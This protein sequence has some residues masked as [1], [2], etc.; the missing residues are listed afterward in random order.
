[1]PSACLG[2]KPPEAGQRSSARLGDDRWGL[3]G[4]RRGPARRG[5]RRGDADPGAH[6]RKSHKGA[7]KAFLQARGSRDGHREGSNARLSSG[8]EVFVEGG[9]ASQA[10]ASQAGGDNPS[11][12]LR[13]WGCGRFLGAVAF[14]LQVYSR[15]GRCSAAGRSSAHFLRPLRAVFP[16][17]CA[18]TRSSLAFG[19]RLASEC[20]AEAVRAADWRLPEPKAFSGARWPFGHRWRNVCSHSLPIFK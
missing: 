1:M 3:S 2:Q 19:R 9:R 14:P 18:S 6:W 10:A 8:T 7:E 16:A 17:G 12:P 20:E 15:R 13:T 11:Q 4:G 5:C